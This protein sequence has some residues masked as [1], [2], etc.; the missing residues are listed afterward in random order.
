MWNRYDPRPNGDRDRG[1][2]GDRND[3]VAA[4]APIA[5]PEASAIRVTCSPRIST[6]R[7]A[8]SAG[9]SKTGS[10]CTI[11][12]AEGRTLATLAAFRVIADETSTG[13]PTSGTARVGL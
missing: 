7:A 13:P 1:D 12:G 8:V 5:T 4:P 3:G 2:V 10:A 9:L 6:C 11:N